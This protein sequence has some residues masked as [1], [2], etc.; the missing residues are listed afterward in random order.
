[1]P[2]GVIK[3]RVELRDGVR[4]GQPSAGDPILRKLAAARV[5][6]A[7]SLHLGAQ[8]AWRAAAS[9]VSGYG[10]AAPGCVAPLGKA[11]DQ[12]HPRVIRLGEQRP[13]LAFFRPADVAG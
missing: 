1:L 13:A 12:P 6:Q 9:R 2:V 11:L 5:T 10:V 7:A 3:P 8:V 4:F